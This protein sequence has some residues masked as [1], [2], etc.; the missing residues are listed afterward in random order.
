MQIWPT[1]ERENFAELGFVHVYTYKHLTTADST[2]LDTQH[3]SR[4]SSRL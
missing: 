1:V 2:R 3:G 4:R